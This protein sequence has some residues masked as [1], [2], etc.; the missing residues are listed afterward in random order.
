MLAIGLV[1]VAVA[2]IMA[3]AAY[4]RRAGTRQV[5]RRFIHLST[6]LLLWSML[7]LAVSICLDFYLVTRLVLDTTLATVLA[8]T[9]FAVFALFW[10]YLPKVWTMQEIES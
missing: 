5:T 4:H 6:R 1:A 2:V 9:L 3:P 8:L 10:F 7:P